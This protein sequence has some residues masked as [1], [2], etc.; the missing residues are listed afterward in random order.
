VEQTRGLNRNH[1]YTLK[2]VFKGAATTIIRHP[3]N[4]C[5]LTA[6][7]TSML[8]NKIAPDMAKLTLARQVAALTLAIWKKEQG[9]DPAK[10]RKT[11]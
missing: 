10:L 3:R 4:D 2:D 6:H 5:P 7:Y 8:E 11:T 9:Y 1:N